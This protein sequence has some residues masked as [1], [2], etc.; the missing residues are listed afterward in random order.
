M[1]ANVLF[2]VEL[3]CENQPQSGKF[4]PSLIFLTPHRLVLDT[5][6]PTLSP[7]LIFPSMVTM[8]AQKAVTETVENILLHSKYC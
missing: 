2:W 4:L 7:P 8:T 5:P 6:T 3:G 1:W